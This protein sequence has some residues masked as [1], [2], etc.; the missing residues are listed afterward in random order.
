MAKFLPGLPGA[1]I[2]GQMGGVVYS[3]N[4][5][6]NYIRNNSS[7]VNPNTPRQVAIRTAFTEVIQH[8]RDTLTIAQRLAW[9]QYAK[10]TKIKDVFGLPITLTAPNMYCR[11][12]IPW[13]DI[14]EARVDAAPATPGQ[15]PML[16]MTITGDTVAGVELTAISPTLLAA[17]R[18]IGLRCFGPV[19]QARNFYNGPFTQTYN[20]A[21]D[22]ALPVVIVIPAQCAVGQRW[23][24]QWRAL[25]ADGR[26]GPTS[27][28][29]VDILA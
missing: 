1:D 24:F 5:Y 16:D 18:I 29:R 8:W 11:F 15:G 3:K 28:S 12:N 9:E 4:R 7:P 14:G 17:D 10:E 27:L 6:G 20:S 21:G 23:Y 19:S 2:R 13:T 26:V 25:I 22:V